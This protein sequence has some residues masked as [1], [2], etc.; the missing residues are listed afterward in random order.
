MVGLSLARLS[1][2]LITLKLA[3]SAYYKKVAYLCYLPD[4]DRDVQPF[5]TL[6]NLACSD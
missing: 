3:P 5:F 1:E 2:A 4:V 6:F